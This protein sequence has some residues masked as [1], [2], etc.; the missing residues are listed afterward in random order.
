MFKCNFKNNFTNK[1]VEM[2]VEDFNLFVIS[3]DKDI[4]TFGAKNKENIITM[5]TTI[6][7]S[8]N[9]DNIDDYIE[10]YN[11]SEA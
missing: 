7:S 8:V 3:K 11:E 9:I 1:E 10:E 5:I 2:V 6:S 4:I